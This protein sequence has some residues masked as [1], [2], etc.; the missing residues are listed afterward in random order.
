MPANL[1]LLDIA[2]EG[3]EL[4][5]RYKIRLHHVA[6]MTMSEAYETRLTEMFPGMFKQL[7]LFA[8]D[9]CDY[10]L[11]KLERN[12]SKDRDD[13]DYVFRT[14]KLDSQALRERYRQEL[15]PYLAKENWHD[16]TL[17]LCIGIFASPN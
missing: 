16:K 4:S 17:E 13:A 2:G 7:R 12:T 1:N 14:Q 3:S 15:R 9:P 10:I 5:N 11:S 8:P 6:V